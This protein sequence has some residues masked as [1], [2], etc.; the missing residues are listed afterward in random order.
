[1]L[2]LL[3]LLMLLLPCA[4]QPVCDFVRLGTGAMTKGGYTWSDPLSTNPN[5]I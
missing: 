1:M 3:L 2:L 4:W 5:P